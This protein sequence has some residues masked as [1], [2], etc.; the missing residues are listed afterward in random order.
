MWSRPGPASTAAVPDQHVWHSAGSY[1]VRGRDGG[2]GVWDARK[3][4]RDCKWGRR[5]VAHRPWVFSLF[6]CAHCVVGSYPKDAWAPVSQKRLGGDGG[7][8]NADAAGGPGGSKVQSL[9]D[10][11][12]PGTIS[13][14]PLGW[15]PGA[16]QFALVN[17]CVRC[18]VRWIM[19]GTC[20]G[21][22]PPS[23]RSRS[24]APRWQ[25]RSCA[26]C[27]CWCHATAAPPTSQLRTCTWTLMRWVTQVVLLR[28]CVCVCVEQHIRVILAG[29]ASLLCGVIM[30]DCPGEAVHARG[31]KPG[32]AGCQ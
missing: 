15:P 28:V 24:T 26:Q 7:D 32:V 18:P 3:P 17:G 13:V 23:L 20:A 16:F 14:V 4:W 6:S 30:D 10:N 25:W 8:K 9:C 11:P 27:V 2:L 21:N 1:A 12:H 29:S 31:S 5:S 22:P 19:R